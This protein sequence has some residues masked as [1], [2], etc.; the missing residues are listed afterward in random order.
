ML[1]SRD[2]SDVHSRL[3]PPAG[4][5]GLNMCHGNILC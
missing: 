2:P 1:R 4:A 5:A 3:D